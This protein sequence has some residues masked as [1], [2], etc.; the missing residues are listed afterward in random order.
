MSQDSS[1]GKLLKTI[2][3]GRDARKK[4]SKSMKSQLQSAYDFSVMEAEGSQGGS[5]AP[6]NISSED[7]PPS[8][9]PHS[10]LILSSAVAQQLKALLTFVS[11]SFKDIAEYRQILE[12]KKLDEAEPSAA[13]A[14]PKPA[15]GLPALDDDASSVDARELA[16]AVKECAN[17]TSLQAL[18]QLEEDV[19]AHF[20]V[21]SWSQLGHGMSLLAT[22]T[23]SSHPELRQMMGEDFMDGCSSAGGGYRLEDVMHAV[24]A[25]AGGWDTGELP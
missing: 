13:A 24:H 3:S 11:T 19:C 8:P 4:L 10:S 12:T 16:Q 1:D 22:L 23:H 9:S 21:T 20:G 17:G 7:T 25:V 6:S 15:T 18:A 5:E 2:A 14:A